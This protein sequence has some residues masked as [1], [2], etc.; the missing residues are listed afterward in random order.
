[1]SWGP[2]LKEEKDKENKVSHSSFPF[3]TAA[4]QPAA[5]SSCQMPSPKVVSPTHDPS[6]PK[7]LMSGTY[8]ITARRK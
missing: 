1:M 3:L 7:L 5:S 2:E 6:F 4:G 8:L